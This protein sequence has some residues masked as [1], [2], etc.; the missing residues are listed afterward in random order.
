MSDDG[1]QS[2]GRFAPPA[3]HRPLPLSFLPCT[4]TPHLLSRHRPLLATRHRWGLP[5]LA[6][7]PA[8]P[9][10]ACP[11]AAAPRSTHTHTRITQ[12]PCHSPPPA[13]QRHECASMPT[14]SSAMQH[15]H[16]HTR[17]SAPQMS[18]PAPS[19]PLPA[20]QPENPRAQPQST[21]H[22]HACKLACVLMH[23]ALDLH[24]HTHA[25]IRKGTHSHSCAR[26]RSHDHVQMPSPPTRLHT[27]P[28]T[29]SACRR[30]VSSLS[31]ADPIK[32][33]RPQCVHTPHLVC[34]LLVDGPYLL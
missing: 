22:L 4:T 29:P 3:H 31:S 10:Q 16:K 33:A 13:M 8:W 26:T 17:H 14:C 27:A 2:A 12:Q 1:R 20:S 6:A 28:G 24:T 23:P 15:T 7:P 34:H 19:A 11:P 5:P 25:R 32:S 30:A 9:G 21:T 18:Y